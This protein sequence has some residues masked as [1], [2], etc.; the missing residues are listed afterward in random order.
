MDLVSL[1]TDVVRKVA[2]EYTFD[3]VG[4]FREN[5]GAKFFDK[6]YRKFLES[7]TD[8]VRSSALSFGTYIPPYPKVELTTTLDFWRNMVLGRS[9]DAH[10]HMME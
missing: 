5:P 2:H 6:H 10:S 9:G 3:D 1:V 7:F 8:F 4:L